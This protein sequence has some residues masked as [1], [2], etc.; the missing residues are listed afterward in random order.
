[1]QQSEV[2]PNC[3]DNITKPLTMIEWQTKQRTNSGRNCW[4]DR[5]KDRQ[6]KNV[7]LGQRQW[8]CLLD[9][10]CCLY[11]LVSVETPPPSV[12]FSSPP[13]PSSHSLW[14]RN[15]RQGLI[16]EC[17][18]FGWA[19]ELSTGAGTISRTL[20][21]RKPY[22][23]LYRR[24]L[25]RQSAFSWKGKKEFINAGTADYVRKIY[26]R[27]DTEWEVEKERRV[28]EGRGGKGRKQE[29]HSQRERER[30]RGRRERLEACSSK[31]D[32]TTR[33]ER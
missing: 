14:P 13:L 7:L 21:Y 30:E 19:N 24:S 27:Q 9:S 31:W 4:N 26:H 28:G 29:M 1:M 5:E 8:P 3:W 23:V 10:K 11:S 20:T 6:L 17:K 25:T 32:R 2:L 16:A 15:P 18:G 22:G 12:H 33:R